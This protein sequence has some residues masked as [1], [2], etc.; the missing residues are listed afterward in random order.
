MAVQSVS[1]EDFERLIH[2]P[3]NTDKRF[4]LIGGEI[5]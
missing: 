5:V 2:L 4:E 3:E 1:M